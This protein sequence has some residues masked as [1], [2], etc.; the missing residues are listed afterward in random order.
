MKLI[1]LL[2]QIN[3]RKSEENG[4][5]CDGDPLY[6]PEVNRGGLCEQA[7]GKREKKERGRGGKMIMKMKLN[8]GDDLNLRI[9]WLIFFL[10]RGFM[11]TN[12]EFHYWSAWGQSPAHSDF[13]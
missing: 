12:Y 11:K 7:L 3:L 2:D 6:P 8:M 4:S 9:V 5:T 1:L 10:T 13:F